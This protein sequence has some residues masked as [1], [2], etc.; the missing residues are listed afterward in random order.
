[1]GSNDGGKLKDFHNRAIYITGGSSGIGLATARLL[2]A[3]GGHIV[4]LARDESKLAAARGEVEA[5]KRSPHQ[6]IA[7]L[8]VDVTDP[9]DVR[10]K[11]QE[12]VAR[13][14]PPDI[15]IAGAG[16]V[17][18]DIFENISLDAFDRVLKTNLYGVRNVIATLLPS[19]KTR[20]GRIAIVASMAGLV[21]MY[22][23]TAYS[24]SKFALVGLAE[25]LR[26]ELKPHGIPVT[27]IC[28]PEVTTPMVAEEDRTISP[29][30]KA[31]KMMAGRLTA[32][33]TARAIVRAIQKRRFLV[34]P[35]KMARL[36]YLTHRLTSGLTTRLTSDWVIRRVLMKKMA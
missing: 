7:T 11:M 3:K 31:V 28:P 2:A 20:G 14:G 35:G 1:M 21:G 16:V 22:G 17:S 12:A 24:T 27:L 4:L 25:C 36:V 5:A 18:N 26:S 19:I 29:E 23:Y 9:L 8:S 30:S 15:L 34:V 6:R 13:F 33:Y 10:S 32:Q